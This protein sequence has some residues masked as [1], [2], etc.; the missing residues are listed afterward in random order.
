M[1]FSVVNTIFVKTAETEAL[2]QNIPGLD[3]DSSSFTIQS[4]SHIM[5]FVV[6]TCLH[7]AQS[8]FNFIIIS[9]SALLVNNNSS[10]L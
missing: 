6:V 10:S 7:A 1:N 9:T 3:E 2:V 4:L 8:H 5:H